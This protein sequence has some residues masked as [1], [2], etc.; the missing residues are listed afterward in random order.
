MQQVISHTAKF[1][2]QNG[3]V[4]EHALMRKQADNPDFAFLKPDHSLYPYYSSLLSAELGMLCYK[5]TGN[6]GT[7]N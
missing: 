4:V 6:G 3:T 2:A 7:D 5:S 1:V